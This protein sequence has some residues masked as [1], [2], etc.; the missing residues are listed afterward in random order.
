MVET[1]CL[2]PHSPKQLRV[3][4]RGQNGVT[5]SWRTSGSFGSNDTPQ[6][7]VEFGTDSSLSVKTDSPIGATTNY[8]KRSFFHNVALLNLSSSTTYYYRIKSASCVRKSG[9]HSFKTPPAPGNQSSTSI[10]I[11]GDLGNNNLINLG[12]P[13]RTIKALQ[14]A[15]ST[16]DFFIH[17]GDIAYA[18][19]YNLG[20]PLE[21][22]EQAW[23][24]FQNNV[25]SIT[26]NNFY[27]VAPGNHEVTCFQLG[28]VFCLSNAY[29][30]F[31]AYANRFRMPGDESGGY[32]NLWYSFDYGLAHVV[33][34]NTE[35]DFPDAP[36]G[37][38]TTLNGGNFVGVQGQL[39]WLHADLQ[40][41]VANR[42]QVPWI[43]VTGHRPFFG[44]LPKLPALPG[45]CD[46]CRLAFQPI[47]LQYNVD[48]YFAGHVHWYERLY[49]ITSTDGAFTQD[50]SDPNGVIH[51]TNGAGGGPEGA[52][53]LKT[54]IDSSAKIV[55]G[56]GYTKLDLQ[57]ASKAKI[58]FVNSKSLQEDD[59]IVVVRQH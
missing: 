53:K 15:A 17:S 23:N 9:I 41:A 11:V 48:F 4:L 19:D 56:Y 47:F 35:T 14:A 49:S 20:L 28:D 52:A 43:I 1:F 8:N 16:T 2:F 46:S 32:K 50:Y 45:N 30:N 38:G 54:G 21:F 57:D 33:V 36:A 25:E 34:I 55:S 37:P 12:A 26:A 18:D 6:P 31:S 40:A 13:S 51:I 22:Y 39:D 24:K 29:R 10:S 3:A 27:M 59:S 7:Q 5:V 42:A 44:S 58:T